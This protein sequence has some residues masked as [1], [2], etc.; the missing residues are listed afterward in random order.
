MFVGKS[1]LCKYHIPLLY[2]VE[3]LQGRNRDKD[4]DCLLAV[5]NLDL[6]QDQTSQRASSRM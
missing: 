2:A 3:A 1:Y 5:A 6:I 4:D